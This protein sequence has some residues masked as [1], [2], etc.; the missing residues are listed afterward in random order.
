MDTNL[1]ELINLLK[2]RL[3]SEWELN[4][5]LEKSSYRE[6]DFLGLEKFSAIQGQESLTCLRCNNQDKELF[7][8]IP[9]EDLTKSALYYCLNCIQMGRLSS[10][11]QLYYL[12]DRA[13]MKQKPSPSFLTWSGQL[14]KEQARASEE[15]LHN[16]SNTA[17]IHMVHAVTGAGKTEIIF[18]IIDYYL[19]RGGR[20]A[21]V[22]PRVD[23]CLELRPRLQEA[24]QEVDIGLL[25][26][27]AEE[28]YRYTPLVVSTT[29]QLLRFQQAFHLIIVDEVDAFPFAGDPALNYAL[30]RA[31]KTEEGKLIYLT[32][33]P[34]H[35]IEELIQAGKIQSTVLPARYHGHPLPE[36]EFKWLGDWRKAIM[37]RNEHSALWKLLRKFLDNEGVKLVFMPHIELANKLY[38]WVKDK[39]G[40]HRI[41]I[42]HAQDPE[43]KNKVMALRQGE[44]DSLITTTILER[45]VTFTHCHV[46]IVGAE[47]RQFTKSSLVQMS[48]RVG[49][50]PDYPKGQLI[51]G[52]FG[53]SRSMIRAREEIRQMNLRARERGLIKGD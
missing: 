6:I 47:H 44:L 48:G 1:L 50:R 28:G 33:T 7:A 42:V 8:Q 23:V 51:Y 20:V 2:G 12:A 53:K 17:M 39:A 24:F 34:S 11:D 29:H 21:V 22:S 46:F 37:E 10:Q 14:S 19:R 49:R 30:E 18:P 43:R 32:A 3:L 35:Q 4:S 13:S 45:G 26:G 5:L 40:H 16:L 27:G 25:Y 41:E 38:Q 9:R 52:H 36:P 31:V 15:L